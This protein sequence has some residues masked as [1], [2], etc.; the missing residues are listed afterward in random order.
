MPHS[1]TQYHNDNNATCAQDGTETAKCDN[2]SATDTRALVNSK[3]PHS[4]THYHNDNNATCTKDGT[5]TAKCDNCTATDTRT[6]PG[7][8]LAHHY[9]GGTCQGCGHTPVGVKITGQPKNVTVVAGLSGSV[10]VTATGD[11]LTYEW[12]YKNADSDTFV[13]ATATGKT[14]TITM[15][16]IVDGRQAYC[17]VRD[18]YGNSV[19]TNTITFTKK[20]TSSGDGATGEDGDIFI[21]FN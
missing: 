17:I 11:G 14:Y 7:T 8:K 18:K 16:D 6:I 13:R 9:V 12:Y 3:L 15:T 21:P 2:C 20:T 5:E 4:F 19:Q 10:T 1:F